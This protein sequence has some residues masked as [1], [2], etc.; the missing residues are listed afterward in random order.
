MLT[1]VELSSVQVIFLIV[2]SQIT[3]AYAYLPIITTPPANQDIWLVAILAA[4]YTCGICLPL[5]FLSNRFKNK[6]LVEYTEKIMGSFI[7]KALG[8]LYAA[9]LVFICLLQLPLLANFLK[10]VVMPETPEYATILLMLAVGVYIVVKGPECTGRLAEILVP[11]IFAVILLFTL[12]N[13]GNMEFESF[14]PVLA[15][16]TFSQLNFGALATAARFS[17]IIVL[18]MLAPC[19]NKKPVAKVFA[20]SIITSTFIFLIIIISVQAVLGVDLPLNLHYPYYT[21]TR[22]IKVFDF[23]EHIEFINI[24]GWVTGI[25]IK[26]SLYF[27]VAALSMAQIFSVKSYKAFIIPIALVSV[28]VTYKAKLLSFYVLNLITSYKVLPFINVIFIAVIPSILLVVYFFRQKSLFDN[29]DSGKCAPR[30]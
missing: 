8:V 5:L 19:I 6:T 30:S 13:I 1:V 12:L 22:T 21:Y 26:F 18:C 11:V 17:E 4:V 10:S 29:D 14:L 9:F 23:V 27:Y 15:D 28:A 16:S 3:T 20:Y 25:L 24:G 2:I 7:G